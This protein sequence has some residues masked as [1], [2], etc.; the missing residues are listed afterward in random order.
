MHLTFTEFVLNSKITVRS[1]TSFRALDHGSKDGERMKKYANL[2]S[3]GTTL[4]RSV[5]GGTQVSIRAQLWVTGVNPFW[6]AFL[7]F[8]SIPAYKKQAYKS[9][10]NLLNLLEGPSLRRRFVTRLQQIWSG[11]V[12]F[13]MIL[14]GLIGL[15]A[16]QD[17]LQIP[18]DWLQA[19][20]TLIGLM[21]SC[22]PIFAYLL[23][24]MR[25]SQAGQAR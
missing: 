7:L 21:V 8:T 24:L 17:T 15:N 22:G 25:R 18:A 5:P 13:W 20:R 16:A 4:Y 23:A 19:I 6:R 9:T 10:A 1:T 3:I 11:W 12:L 2:E 14:A